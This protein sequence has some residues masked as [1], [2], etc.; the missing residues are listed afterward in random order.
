MNL[1]FFSTAF[2]QPGDPFRARYNL[3]LCEALALEHRVTVISPVAWTNARR[4]QYPPSLPGVHYP[5]FFYPP[6]LARRTHAWW[7]WQSIRGTARAVVDEWKPDAV[8][9]YWTWPDGAGAARIAR[10]CGAPAIMIVGGSDVLVLAARAGHRRLVA[11]TL[12]QASAVVVVSETLRSAV[13]ALGVP[14]ER[15][16]VIR[17]GVDREVFSPG[18]PSSARRRLGLPDGERLLL[19]VGRLSAVKG[20]DVLIDALARFARRARWPWRCVIIGKGPLGGGLRRR[21]RRAALCHCV[22]FI[23]RLEPP[24]LA[25]WYRAADGLILSSRSEALPNV[26]YEAKA[27]GTPVVA[28]NVGDVA[29]FLDE[30]DRLVPAGDPERLAAGIAELLAAP[31]ALQPAPPLPT[32]TDSAAAFTDAIRRL[33]RHDAMSM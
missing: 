4:G 11:R 32:W 22:S 19:W 14:G 13:G 29:A 16:R 28:T 20:P 27:C 26:L 17:R 15:I 8:I 2:P 30:G 31:R 23:D 10:A 1:L 6:G 18:S 9:S 21:V 3:K 25:N 7:L 24:A 33:R 5:R 12:A